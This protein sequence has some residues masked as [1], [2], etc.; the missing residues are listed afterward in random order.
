VSA[1]SGLVDDGLE[2]DPLAFVAL[3]TWE[4]CAWCPVAAMAPTGTANTIATAAVE[5]TKSLPI[6]PVITSPSFE[7][8]HHLAVA[9]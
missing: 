5:P 4:W 2:P 7:G 6:L 3:L 8:V 9:R 1:V